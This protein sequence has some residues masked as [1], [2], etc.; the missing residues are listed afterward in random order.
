MTSSGPSSVTYLCPQCQAKLTARPEDAGKRRKCPRCGKVVKVPGTRE[1]GEAASSRSR[2]AST[3]GGIANIPVICPLCGTRMYATPDQIGQTM[4]CPDCLESVVVPNRSPPKRQTPKPS[5]DSAAEASPPSANSPETSSGGEAKSSSAGEPEEADEYKLADEVELPPHR[6]LSPTLG[7]LVDRHIEPVQG[8]EEPGAGAAGSHDVEPPESSH[9]SARSGSFPVKCPVCD[10][11]LEATEDEIGTTKKCP[12]CFSLIEIKR[13]PPTRRR[14]HR[15]PESEGE[16]EDFVLSDPVPLDV[17]RPTDREGVP[18]TV[19]EEA[20]RNARRAREEQRPDGSELPLAPLWSGL[21]AFLLDTATVVRII[22]GGLLLGGMMKLAHV[23]A[24]A[25]MAA[26]PVHQFLAMIG[27]VATLVLGIVTISLVSTNFLTVLQQSAEGMDRVQGWPE[28]SLVEWITE[29]MAYFM[30]A[31]FAVTPGMLLILLFP[32]IR[33]NPPLAGSLI[34]VSLYVLFPM[35]QLSI[36]ESASVTT[37]A[38][39][40]VWESV[41]EQFLLWCTFYL[42]TFVLAWAVVVALL[43]VSFS[44]PT[45]VVIGLGMFISFVALLYARML[46]RLVW[47]CHMDVMAGQEPREEA[48]DEP[49]RNNNFWLRR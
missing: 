10:T 7:R 24:A 31:F 46:G 17:Y 4:V 42:M 33:T 32:G 5:A 40:L 3:T 9:A 13:P 16:E 48:G 20:L 35:T 8:D 2:A 15:R 43:L 25:A 22:V 29:G 19:G 1:Q 41:R 14:V 39:K 18:R 38:S 27:S 49:R 12:D 34:G 30:A 26:N 23:S 36:L 11:M 28:N 37:P 47:A 45:F 6:T 44:D 21:F